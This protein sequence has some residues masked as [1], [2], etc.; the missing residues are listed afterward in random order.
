MSHGRQCVV[1]RGAQ[2]VAMVLQSRPGEGSLDPTPKGAR[3]AGAREVGR[4]ILSVGLVHAIVEAIAG[5]IRGR[6]QGGDGIQAGEPRGEGRTPPPP[7]SASLPSRLAA[8]GGRPQSCRAVQPSRCSLTPCCH[9]EPTEPPMA[10][11]ILSHAS[12]ADAP[13]RP[14]A[15]A[16]RRMMAAP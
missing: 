1:E 12:Q 3:A 15:M 2:P 14:V 13:S 11:A 5:W 16:S 9:G 7:C 4:D 6:E 8:R 10:A